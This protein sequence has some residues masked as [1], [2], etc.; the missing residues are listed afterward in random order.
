MRKE[1]LLCPCVHKPGLFDTKET[2]CEDPKSCLP[3][4]LPSQCKRY[5][6]QQIPSASSVSRA[7]SLGFSSITITS[8]PVT[9][10]CGL[11]FYPNVRLLL[12][13]YG[14]DQRWMPVLSCAQM[15]ADDRIRLSKMKIGCGCSS[16]FPHNNKNGMFEARHKWVHPCH[17][18]G[19]LI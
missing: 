14:K 17:T 11:M 3:L 15:L 16:T 8:W 12:S 13:I 10:T 19:S 6:I 1:F 2:K 7:S 4:A 18:M 9:R 5:E